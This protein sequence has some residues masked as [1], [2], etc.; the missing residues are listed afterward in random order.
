MTGSP[1]SGISELHIP[2]PGKQRGYGIRWL[3]LFCDLMPL[4]NPDGSGDGKSQVFGRTGAF[5]YEKLTAEK[6][7]ASLPSNENP[8][9]LGRVSSNLFNQTLNLISQACTSTLG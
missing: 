1:S 5:W 4:E 3:S 7:E 9:C 6:E 8:A 2:G